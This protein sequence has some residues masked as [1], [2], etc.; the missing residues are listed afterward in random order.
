MTEKKSCGAKFL[1]LL[2]A[3]LIAAVIVQSIVLFRLYRSSTIKH[4]ASKEPRV[5]APLQNDFDRDKWS[6]LDLDDWDPY[7]EMQRMQEQMRRMFDDS[8]NRFRASPGFID[9]WDDIAFT[10]DYDLIDDG[11]SYI[12]KFNIPGADKAKIDISISDWV[13]TVKGS[14]NE[15]IE[16]KGDKIFRLE[17]RSGQFQRSVTLPGAVDSNKMKAE[18]KNGILTVEVP[19]SSKDTS[20]NSSFAYDTGHRC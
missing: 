20:R 18:Y 9:K 15:R 16:R 14:T 10:P 8:F 12:L 1:P 17:R 19:K 5:I 6:T 2:I 11:K 13:L 3:V 4:T 7:V